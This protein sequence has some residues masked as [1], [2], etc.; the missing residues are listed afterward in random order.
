MATVLNS[1]VAGEQKAMSL[2]ENLDGDLESGYQT[3]WIAGEP[4]VINGYS[5]TF[6]Q[7]ASF[8]ISGSNLSYNRQT[9][10][11]Y[12]DFTSGT[13]GNPISGGASW[14]TEAGQ[15][16]YVF[17][18]VGLAA[19][20]RSA[21]LDMQGAYDYITA[22]IFSETATIY[23]EHWIKYQMIVTG[24]DDGSGPAQM[25]MTR[26]G[27]GDSLPNISDNPNLTLT[28]LDVNGTT[29][30]VFN[31]PSK[32]TNDAAQNISGYIT[33]PPDNNWHKL[34][35]AGKISDLATANGWRYFKTDAAGSLG[36]CAT[37]SW[38]NA[39][40]TKHFASPNGTVAKTDWAGEAW[41][42]KDVADGSTVAGGFQKVYLPFFTR[43]YQVSEVWIAGFWLNDT[44]ERVVISSSADANTALKTGIIQPNISRSNDQWAF[45]CETGNLPASGALYLYVVNADGIFN[46]SP[47]QIRS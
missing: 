44:A 34:H 33:L 16:P 10:L 30:Q 15:D 23:C 14:T 7:G 25:K 26:I 20:K 6:T 27:A 29:P 12:D 40:P 41:A 19:G 4:P 3:E 35:M 22:H 11:F 43:T 31:S 24:P 2:A 42:T 38:A 18:S 37:A 36:D 1:I 47:L 28:L 21:Y 45:N 5:G 13:L 9:Q 32:S 8:T 39:T 46:T 17:S